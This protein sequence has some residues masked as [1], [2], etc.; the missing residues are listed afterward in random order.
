M[1]CRFC[2]NKVVNDFADLGFSPPSNSFLSEEQLNQSETFYP[3]KVQV[4]SSCFL[5][6]VDEYA[7]HDEIFDKD[8]IYFSSYS[9]SWLEHARN[10]T[11]MMIKRF[12]FNHESNVFE[13]ASNDGYLLQY[14]K[15]KNINVLGIEPTSNTADVAISRGIKTMVRFFG[16]KLAL[17]LQKN[18]SYADL[19]LGNNVLAHVPDINDFVSGLPLVLKKEGIITFEF[20]HLMELMLNNQFDTIYH[21]H[22][23]YLSLFSIQIIF[24]KH[25]LKIFDVDQIM[26]HGG[27]LRIYATHSNNSEQSMSGNVSILL[28]EELKFGINS[29][30]K[31][32]TFQNF[33]E[34][35]KDNFLSFLLKAKRDDKKVIGYGAAAKGVTLL[36]FCGVRK[37]LVK[38][39]VDK[40]PHKIDKYIP[41]VHIP[42]LSEKEISNYKP[43][44]VVILPWNIKDEIIQQL[45]YV[46]D[47]GCKFVVAIPTLKVF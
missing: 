1:N 17:E 28:N 42:V 25:N 21:E 16:K 29:I 15:E 24:K 10:Y 27:S 47:W 7:K 38:F 14:F 45:Q 40:S 19:I 4:C 12:N 33:T 43:D 11:D 3:L 20:P 9:S 37:D 46:T 5:V 23:S 39:I 2:N 36:N 30:K 41:G 35:V 26:T 44:Y 31:Y 13:I 6:Q 32:N 8:Y 34:L 22:F 18:N